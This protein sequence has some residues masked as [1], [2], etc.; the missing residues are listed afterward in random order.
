MNKIP[1]PFPSIPNSFRKRSQIASQMSNRS[2]Y[3]GLKSITACN[4][5]AQS[6]ATYR[7][8]HKKITILLYQSI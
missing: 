7:H 8:W 6:L 3:Q 5:I 4:H 1:T 2:N